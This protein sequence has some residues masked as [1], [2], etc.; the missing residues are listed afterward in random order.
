MSGP[1]SG[2]KLWVRARQL[3]ASHRG[4]RALSG[5]EWL[6]LAREAH[7][8][9]VSTFPQGRRERALRGFVERNC[10]GQA[11]RTIAVFAVALRLVGE[12]RLRGEFGFGDC[13]E[14]AAIACGTTLEELPPPRHPLIEPAPVTAPAT[15]VALGQEPSIG[16][17][18]GIGGEYWN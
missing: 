15:R 6:E 11:P 16:R 13:L 8:F 2:G 18:Q 14:A 9:A 12:K 4:E 7:E 17:R 5:E 1:D 3:L 10:V